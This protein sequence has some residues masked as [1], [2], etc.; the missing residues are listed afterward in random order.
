MKSRSGLVL[1]EML[2]CILVFAIS[3]VLCLQVFLQADRISTETT[4]RDQAVLLAQNGA[5]TMKACAGNL[6]QVSLLLNG[7]VEYG[8]VTVQSEDIYMEITPCDSNTAGLGMA[9]IC[10]YDADD[11]TLVFSLDTAWQEVSD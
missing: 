1:M 10:V 8:L 5:E 7:S 4:L 9:K 11:S 3:A 2:I 6:K